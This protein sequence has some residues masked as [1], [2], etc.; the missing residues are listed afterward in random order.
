MLSLCYAGATD[1][2][3]RQCALWCWCA[4]VVVVFFF[5]LKGQGED[6]PSD[7][8]AEKEREGEEMRGRAAGSYL[9][10]KAD[11]SLKMGGNKRKR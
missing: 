10:H 6:F 3:E 9:D 1:H 8:L 2:G 5:F 4:I 11:L 7:H